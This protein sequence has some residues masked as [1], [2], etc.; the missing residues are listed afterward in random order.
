MIKYNVMADI[1]DPPAEKL[2]IEDGKLRQQIN[3][4]LLKIGILKELLL[5]P[6][7]NNFTLISTYINF[8]NIK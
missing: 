5:Y 6:F 8:E 1:L 3:K 2:Y 4:K 7:R